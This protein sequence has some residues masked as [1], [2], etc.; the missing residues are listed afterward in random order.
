MATIY[1]RSRLD[2]LTDGI[3]AVAMTLLVL[4]IR[5]PEDVH[6]LS[7][8]SLLVALV[9]LL[10]KLIPYIISFLV[11]GFHWMSMIKTRTRA[12]Y[13]GGHH[14][15]LTIFDL[16][17][18]TFLPFSATLLGRF[19]DRAAAVCIYSANLGLLALVGLWTITV[20]SD[21]ERDW[22]ARERI[23]SSLTLFAS[24]VLAGGASFFAPRY[25]MWIYLVNLLPPL[26]RRRAHS[27]LA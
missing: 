9:K 5:L 20:G 12:E 7:E 19:P 13:I 6:A 22:R 1:P 4:D 26:I 11:L 18:V 17:F 21:I 27:G 8:G 23:V 15:A 25:A 16:L 10:P 24:A 3:Y 2:A 14:A